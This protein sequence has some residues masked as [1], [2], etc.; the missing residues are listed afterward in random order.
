MQYETEVMPWRT[1]K[2]QI[3]G[4]RTIESRI[5]DVRN[6]LAVDWQV[7]VSRPAVSAAATI[8]YCRS[9]DTIRPHH[10]SN[11]AFSAC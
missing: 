11:P 7:R 10:P 2:T 3:A 9:S 6:L 5:E 1:I 8:E 4:L